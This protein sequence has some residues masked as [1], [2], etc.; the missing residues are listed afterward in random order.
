MDDRHKKPMNC[1]ENKIIACMPITVKLEHCIV[2]KGP[3]TQSPN[4]SKN[5]LP[6]AHLHYMMVTKYVKCHCCVLHTF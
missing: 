2:T 3:I 4:N 5:I 1:K 6:N